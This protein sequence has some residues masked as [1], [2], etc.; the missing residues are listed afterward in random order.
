MKPFPSPALRTAFR[1]LSAGLAVGAALAV[2]TAALSGCDSSTDGNG[3]I[4]AGDNTI[5]ILAPTG[6]SFKM[7]DML[8]VIAKSDYSKFSSGL[9]YQLSTDSSKTWHLM[10]ANVRKDGIA[11]DT[12]MWDPVNDPPGD[13][14]AGKPLL[15]RVIDYDKKHFA[16]S[17]YFTLTN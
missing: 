17:N 6:G 10:K 7:S 14:P 8:Q 5:Q 12:L 13:V 2:M 1:G 16:I 3:N 15:I 9:N 4:P 11:L